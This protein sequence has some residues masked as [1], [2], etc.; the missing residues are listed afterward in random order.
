MNY[1]V[2][3]LWSMSITKDQSAEYNAIAAKKVQIRKEKNNCKGCSEVG[4][5]IGTT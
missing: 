2:K 1:P 3:S 5:K 4:Q